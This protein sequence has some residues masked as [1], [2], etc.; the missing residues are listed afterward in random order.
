MHEH[1]LIWPPL[2]VFYIHSMLFNSASAVRSIVRLEN[3]FEKIPTQPA[4]EIIDKLPTKLILNELQN[5]VT[6]AGALSRYF[7]PVR[8][9]YAARAC[10]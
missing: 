7:W 5:M 6:Q 4:N 1:S 2:E 3:I 8:K 9:K 10:Y